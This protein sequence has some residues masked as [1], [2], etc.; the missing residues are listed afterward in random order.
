MAKNSSQN[1]VPIR[2]IRSGVIILNSGNMRAILSTTSLNLSLKSEDEQMG[3]ITAFQS[4]LNSLDFN[5]QI[6][7]QSK[8]IDIRDYIKSLKERER[9]A[10]EELLKIQIKEYTD[11][12]QKFTEEQNIMTKNFYIVVPYDIPTLV[13]N[14]KRM[15]EMD[16]IKNENQLMQRVSIVVSGLTA[17]GLKL[18]LIDTEEIV[19]L[20][21]KL[22][23]PNE[24]D[25]NTKK[26]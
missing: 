18:K 1:F 19:G 4:F 26:L 6:F 13:G 22:F 9:E 7:V 5:V 17:L 21:Y 25:V 23:N 3:I 8:K 15:N 24:L 16:F 12:I 14:T 10:S 2:E 11:F 20:F